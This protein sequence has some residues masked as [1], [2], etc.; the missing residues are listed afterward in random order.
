MKENSIIL[1][2]MIALRCITKNK[3]LTHVFSAFLMRL[4]HGQR[5]SLKLA[6]KDGDHDVVLTS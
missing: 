3:V 6:V 4:K 1:E 5:E 2:Y